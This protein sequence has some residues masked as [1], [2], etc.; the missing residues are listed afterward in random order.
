MLDIMVLA[1]QTNKTRVSTFMFLNDNSNKSLRFIG[2]NAVHHLLSHKSKSEEFQRANQYYI[3]K[4]AY[5]VS[6]NG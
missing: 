3:E 2:I 4:L 5:L 1:F 6:A